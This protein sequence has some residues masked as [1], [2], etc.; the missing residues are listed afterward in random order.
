MNAAANVAFANRQLITHHVRETFAGV[1]GTPAHRLG[2]S[3]VYDVCH[4]IAKIEEHVVAGTRGSRRLLVHRKGA[5]RAF[6]PGAPDLPEA[7]R[8]SG[9]PIIIGGSMET[10]SALLAGTATAM[11]ETFGSTAHGAGRTMSRAQAKKQVRG[12]Q[13]LRD[14]EARGIVVRAASKSGLAEEAGF[15]YKNLDAVIDVLER[16]GISRPVVRLRPIGNIKG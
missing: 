12:E 10:G 16:T 11:R 14:M 6:G 13:L 1:F 15:A 8:A 7:Y 5:T 3:V 9:Q 2:L 4:N